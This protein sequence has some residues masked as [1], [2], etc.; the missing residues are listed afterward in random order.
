MKMRLFKSF[1]FHERKDVQTFNEENIFY[2]NS[3]HRTQKVSVK[4]RYRID[5]KFEEMDK[6]CRKEIIFSKFNNYSFK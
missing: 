6:L 4:F 5:F 3:E 2:L 1:A